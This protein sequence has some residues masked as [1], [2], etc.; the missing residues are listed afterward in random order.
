MLYL[1]GIATGP[2]HGSNNYLRQGRYW[3]LAEIMPAILLSFA[4]RRQC[5]V[6]Y[7]GSPL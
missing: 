6:D 1:F 2:S 5:E 4:E 7:I 3:I